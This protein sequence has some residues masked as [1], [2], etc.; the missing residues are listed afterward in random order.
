MDRAYTPDYR[1]LEEASQIIGRNKETTGDAEK[2]A[3]FK[4][5]QFDKLKKFATLNNLWLDY[6]NSPAIFLDK[7][8][9]NEVFHDCHS[10][11][12]K[13][14]NFEYA[15]DD[16]SNFFIRMYAHNHFF[17]NVPYELIGFSRNSRNEFCAVLRQPYIHA[18]REATED[19]IIR[20]MKALGFEMIYR[21]EFHN[22]EYEIFDAEP[23]NVLYGLDDDLYFID[24]QIR[25]R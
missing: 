3:C 11:V 19:E 17:S 2:A 4:R 6:N 1:I 7:G 10:S 12:I 9:E 5:E 24:T 23:H 13:L 22:S 25:K 18:T 21:D 14:N 15:G 16:L 20:Y 8:G